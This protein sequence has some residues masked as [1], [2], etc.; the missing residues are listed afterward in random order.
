MVGVDVERLERAVTREDVR[1]VV[2]EGRQDA[3]VVTVVDVGFRIDHVLL[4]GELDERIAV[5]VHQN[6]ASAVRIDTLQDRQAIQECVLI[7]NQL[8]VGRS[9]RVGV[10]CRQA[11]AEVRTLGTEET[12]IEVDQRIHGG[13]FA[14]FVGQA[15]SLRTALTQAFFARFVNEETVTE[16]RNAV[17]IDFDQS[18]VGALEAAVRIALVFL[19]G[20]GNQIDPDTQGCRSSTFWLHP[21]HQRQSASLQ[22]LLQHGRL[23]AHELR[24]STE[25]FGTVNR[26]EAIPAYHIGSVRRTPGCEQRRPGQEDR[27]VYDLQRLALTAHILEAEHFRARQR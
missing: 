20:L 8:G 23:V 13:G 15:A 27:K 3:L 19:K 2:F 17:A 11:D 16:T 22:N 1:I 14:V 12:T 5:Q 26:T 24:T 4:Q 6:L 21:A 25:S 18:T 10:R 9:R 7:F